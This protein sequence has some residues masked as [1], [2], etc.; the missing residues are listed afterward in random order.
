MKYKKYSEQELKEMNLLSDGVYDFETLEVH[1]TD[2]YHNPLKTKDGFEMAK[3]KLGVIDKNGRQRY[4]WVWLPGD[5]KMAFKFRHYADTVGQIDLYDEDKFEIAKT[6]G[7][8]GKAHIVV[9]KGQAK[10]D[11]S[12]F[13]DDKNDVKDF[14]KR[15]EWEVNEPKAT[16]STDFLD[17]DIPNM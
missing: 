6:L 3:L 11:G 15:E 7:L 13:W 2:Q 5:G 4:V 9:Q 17:D 14:I 12:G 1:E 8:K 16:P 10:Q